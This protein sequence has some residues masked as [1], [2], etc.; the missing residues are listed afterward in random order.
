MMHKIEF[1]EISRGSIV[2]TLEDLLRRAKEGKISSIA[3]AGQQTDETIMTG[4]LICHDGSI[5]GLVGALQALSS[6]IIDQYHQQ[7]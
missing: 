5:Y 4:K 1:L 3:I 7:E 6:E 2:L